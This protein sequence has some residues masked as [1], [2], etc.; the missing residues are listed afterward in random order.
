VRVR[1]D[2]EL[3]RRWV[4]EAVAGSP[5]GLEKDAER[6]GGERRSKR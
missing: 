1:N 6:T 2:N 3:L 5:P 4:V